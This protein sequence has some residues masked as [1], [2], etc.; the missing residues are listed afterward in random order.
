MNKKDLLLLFLFLIS[1]LLSFPFIL[2]GMYE[3]RKA[4]FVYFSLFMGLFSFLTYP[5]SDLFRHFENYY[6]YKLENIYLN[7]KRR[8]G[9][10]T[11]LY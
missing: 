7:W 2:V 1:P 10:V 5:A 9:I 4:S 6:Y 3:R 11:P 8:A